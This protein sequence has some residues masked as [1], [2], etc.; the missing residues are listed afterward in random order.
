MSSCPPVTDRGDFQHL[1]L[2]VKAL[3]AVMYHLPDAV[4]L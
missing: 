2:A 4:N 3:K 1:I